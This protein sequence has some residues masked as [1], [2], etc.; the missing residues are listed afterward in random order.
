M[1]RHAGRGRCGCFTCHGPHLDNFRDMESLLAPWSVAEEVP[2]AEGLAR[3]IGQRASSREEILERQKV[4]QD[5]RNSLGG[6]SR[7]VVSA[8]KPWIE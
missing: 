1:R 4:A 6:I 8:L 5:L 7:E 3:W 2:D